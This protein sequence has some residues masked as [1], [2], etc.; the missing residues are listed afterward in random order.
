MS[1]SSGSDRFQTWLIAARSGDRKA[2][3]ELL[4]LLE[5]RFRQDAERR[6]GHV[7]RGRTRVS[8]VLQDAYVEVVRSIGAFEGATESEF[9]A[10]VTTI[11]ENSARRQHRHLTAKK[12][13]PP[14]RTSELN[15]LAAVFF[16]TVS[17]PLSDLQKAEDVQMVFRALDEMRDDHRV[18]I[19]QIVLAARPVTEVADDLGR[20]EQATR[21][22]LSR[23]RAAL[24]V[25]LDKL[26]RDRSEN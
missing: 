10:W 9:Y 12:R 22:L 11:I 16:R 1:E 23:A 5:A 3:D 17:S 7:L 26:S 14:S 25:K 19:E 13:K 6:V 20:T 24:T 8:D 4:S 18:V 2:L 21:M 15:A